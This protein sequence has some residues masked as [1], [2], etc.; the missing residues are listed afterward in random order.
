[1]LYLLLLKDIGKI[2]KN[3]FHCIGKQR[4]GYL[5]SAGSLQISETARTALGQNKECRTSPGSLMYTVG[6]QELE[7]SL[8][9]SQ[10][11]G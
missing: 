8:T 11:V 10:D 7:S 6:I 5:S 4:N 9:A 1:M 3:F 2:K